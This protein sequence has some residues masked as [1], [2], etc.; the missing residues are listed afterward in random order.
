M[1]NENYNIWNYKINNY[2]YNINIINNNKIIR[3]ENEKNKREIEKSYIIY[4][5]NWRWKEIKYYKKKNNNIYIYLY[6]N[7]IE[8]RNIIFKNNKLKNENYNIWN[9]EIN[10]NNQ[11]FN[12]SSTFQLNFIA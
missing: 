11:I 10:E 7:K 12:E 9:N 1:K 2:N 4:L 3:I 5:K 6:I 8:M